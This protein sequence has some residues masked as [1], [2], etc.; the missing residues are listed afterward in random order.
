[1][2]TSI[3]VHDLDRAIAELAPLRFAESWDNVGLQIGSP[4]AQVGVVL[5][6]VDVTIQ[7]VE[8]AVRKGA[9]ALVVHH[10]VL[11]GSVSSVRSDRWPGCV[12]TA[13]IEARCALYV[14]HTNLD[15]APRTNSSAAL[16]RAVGLT[17]VRPLQ[18]EFRQELVAIG[19]ALPL[20]RRPGIVARL[21]AIG[22]DVRV[23]SPAL[24]EALPGARGADVVE[25]VCPHGRVA[26]ILRAVG[27]AAADGARAVDVRPVFGPPPFPSL[28]VIGTC[29]PITAEALADRVK[30]ALGLGCVRVAAAGQHEITEAAVVAGSAKGAL[31]AVGAAGVGAFIAGEIGHHPAVEA[32]ANGVSAIEVGHFASE[33]PAMHNLAELLRGAFGDTLEIM[34]SAV[35]KAP[36]A[37]R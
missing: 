29:E 26:A 3:S 8:E 17:D 21:S 28:G 32:A 20:D 14:A 35:E 12:V 31:G 30:L 2:A 23:A 16:A 7:V 19:L 37:S 13:L 1:M 6:A 25:V 9:D 15:L 11:F 36:F 18:A 24:A 22:E 33:R 10:P 34:V 5:V 27:R 4:E